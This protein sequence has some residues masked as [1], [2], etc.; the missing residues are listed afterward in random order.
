MVGVEVKAEGIGAAERLENAGFN[1]SVYG[2]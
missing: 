2:F 1:F